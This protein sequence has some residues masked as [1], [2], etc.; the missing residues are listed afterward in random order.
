MKRG[1]KIDAEQISW[2]EWGSREMISFHHSCKILILYTVIN[3]EWN[4]TNW[5][6]THLVIKHRVSLRPQ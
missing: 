3:F 4:H 5:F 1:Y 6:L 2:L